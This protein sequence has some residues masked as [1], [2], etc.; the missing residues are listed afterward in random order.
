MKSTSSAKS[1]ACK[2]TITAI[3]VPWR[4][5]RLHT[6]QSLFEL[7]MYY[8]YVV[9]YEEGKCVIRPVLISSYIQAVRSDSFPTLP[10]RPGYMS[11]NCRPSQNSRSKYAQNWGAPESIKTP[12]FPQNYMEGLSLYSLFWFMGFRHIV[13]YV[14][15]L[16]LAV[17]V[18]VPVSRVRGIG[19]G[20]AFLDWDQTSLG[21]QASR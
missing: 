1:G 17:L 4:R 6:I 8:V 18:V 12:E 19:F 9:I 11:N 10:S 5:L 13:I 16:V 20:I 21:F 14:I 15:Y 7:R 2:A 3:L